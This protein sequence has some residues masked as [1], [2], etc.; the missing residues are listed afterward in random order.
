MRESAT[1]AEL[2]RSRGVW[3]PIPH[4]DHWLARRIRWVCLYQRRSWELQ[5]NCRSL[6]TV[7]AVHAAE[8]RE[9]GDRTDCEFPP[10]AEIDRAIEAGPMSASRPRW[11]ALFDD[12]ADA[13]FEDPADGV[14]A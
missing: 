8:I 14:L 2:R 5:R 12:P 6:E 3:G 9:W 10:L 1:A 13:L 4:I 11:P 7:M